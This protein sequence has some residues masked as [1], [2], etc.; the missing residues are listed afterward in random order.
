MNSAQTR[1]RAMRFLLTGGFNAGT[2]VLF[3]G[4]FA[5]V[6]ASPTLAFVSGYLLSLSISYFANALFV[7]ETRELS[8]A[9][10]GRFCLS[11]VPNFTIQ[12]VAVQA[13]INVLGLPP[14]L[15]YAL[16]V[17]V[18][19]PLTFALLSLFAF[20]QRSTDYADSRV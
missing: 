6:L 13:L 11:Y 5:L 18:A 9:Q 12:L 15:A 8:V 1:R 20:K 3:S 4:L 14:V 17:A 2:C 10:F 16:S 19:V 7:F